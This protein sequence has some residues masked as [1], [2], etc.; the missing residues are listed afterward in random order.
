MI[1]APASFEDLIWHGQVDVGD[2][3]VPI[4]MAGEGPP[5]ILLHGWTL[6]WRMWLP[7][8]VA[9]SQCFLLVMP[10]RRGFGRSTAPPDL[11]KEAEDVERIADFLGFDRYALLGLSQGAAVV[12]DCAH[13]H[14]SR[15]NSLVISGAPIPGLVERDEAIDLDRYE[16]WVRAG[17]M[18]SMRAD[19]SRHELM[20]HENPATHDL[21]EE[22]LSDYDGRDLIAPSHLHGV[23]RDSLAH[24]PMPLLA[25]T[26]Q[27]DSKWR[28]DC[29]CALADIALRGELALIE[30][31]GH[32]ANLDNPERFNR[33]VADFLLKCLSHK[34][35]SQEPVWR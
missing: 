34:P 27:S 35:S 30:G 14:G 18:A 17:D 26:G 12:L 5:L 13:R 33:I 23:P 9:L 8:I 19:W 31:A 28:R 15:I 10:D 11:T 20:R 16:A 24:L 4:A 7:Q 21:V 3:I 25:M 22:I 29:A 1:D 32:L 2:G 6:D